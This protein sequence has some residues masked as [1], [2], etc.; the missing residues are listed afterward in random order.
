MKHII[1]YHAQCLDG[2][3]SAATV[4]KY[5]NSLEHKDISF[6]PMTYQMGFDLDF[7]DKDTTLWIVDFSFPYELLK[8]MNDRCQRIVWYDHHI[9]SESIALMKDTLPNTEITIDI[10]HSAAYIVWAKLFYREPPRAIILSEDRDLWK[11]KFPETRSFT[12]G[13][14]SYSDINPDGSRIQG[15]LVYDDMVKTYIAE[16]EVLRRAKEKR[17]NKAINHGYYGKIK[18]HNAFFVNATEDI[19]EIGEKI[20]LSHEDPI[21][22]VIYNIGENVVKFSLRSN[23]I[24]VEKIAKQF[25]GGGHVGAAGFELKLRMREVEKMLR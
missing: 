2:I 5:L 16:G 12:E 19:S 15:L 22:A 1:V 23:T 4:Y 6:I 11:F 24:N 7:L 13:L 14:F 20:Y 8:D 9:S 25:H 10:K 21:V 17:V 3:F 18:G